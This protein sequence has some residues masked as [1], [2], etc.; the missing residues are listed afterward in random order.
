MGTI[1]NHIVADLE[2]IFKKYVEKFDSKYQN[3]VEEFKSLYKDA[4][5]EVVLNNFNTSVSS[6]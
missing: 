5:N 3:W 6:S 2:K 1:K 4:G